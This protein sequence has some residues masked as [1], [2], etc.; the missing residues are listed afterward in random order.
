VAQASMNAGSEVDD[1]VGPAVA[2]M[3]TAPMTAEADYSIDGLSVMAGAGPDAVMRDFGLDQ[4][5]VASHDRSAYSADI[6]FP[7]FATAGVTSS[8]Y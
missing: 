7:G 2:L 5:N 1:H 6:A 3:E 4:I 8:V